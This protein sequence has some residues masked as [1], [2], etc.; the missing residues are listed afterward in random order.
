MHLAR[1]AIVDAFT[2]EHAPRSSVFSMLSAPRIIR[3]YG[4][5]AE[6]ARLADATPADEFFFG[7]LE[8]SIDDGEYHMQYFEISD[9]YKVQRP[10]RAVRIEIVSNHGDDF[11]CLYRIRVHG[12]DA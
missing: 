4:Y 9:E 10:T 2:V 5:P 3:V 11:T 8:Y 7:E 12:T 1:P 6:I